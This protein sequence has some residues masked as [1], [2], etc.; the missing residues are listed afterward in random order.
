MIMAHSNTALSGREI[1]AGLLRKEGTMEG[2]LKHSVFSRQDGDCT[3]HNVLVFIVV[4]VWGGGVSGT[5]ERESVFF[6][7]ILECVC[8]FMRHVLECVCVTQRDSKSR[9]VCSCIS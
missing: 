6:W 2:G 5:P 4:C 3:L 7:H 8:G 9:C 1:D